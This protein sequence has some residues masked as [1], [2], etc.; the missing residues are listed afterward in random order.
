M[1]YPKG[2][3]TLTIIVGT[4]SKQLTRQ[5]DFLVV[6]CPSSY[7]VIIGRPTLNKWKLA[8]STYCLKVKF[9]TENGVGEVRGDQVL[10]R[11]CYQAVLVVKENHRWMIEEKEEDKVEALEEVE[12]VEGKTTKT[13]RIGTTLSPEMRSMLV[14]FLK[15]NLDVFA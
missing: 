8:T 7:N 13:T 1:V 6:D 5:L 9:P 14:Q 11:E 3:A 2:I 4:Y 12:L 15:E 10:A